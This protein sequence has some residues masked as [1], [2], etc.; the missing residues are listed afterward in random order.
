VGFFH[1]EVKAAPKPATASGR[2][3]LSDIPIHA[4]ADIGCKICP[5][6]DD[7]GSQT[8]LAPVGDSDR[9]GVYLLLPAPTEEDGFVDLSTTKPRN[10]NDP[11]LS[12]IVGY[13]P[14]HDIR[15]GGLVQCAVGENNPSQ[16]E[17]ACCRNRVIADI[18]D[19]KPYVVVGVGDEVLA[20]AT[21]LPAYSP[22]FRGQLFVVKIGA[23]VCYYYQ[24]NAPSWAVKKKKYGKSE[25]E[26]TTAHDLEMLRHS[27]IDL[28]LPDPRTL[29]CEHEFIDYGVEVITGQ[30]PG[31]MQRLEEAMH[32]SMQQRRAAIDIETN[33][34]RPWGKDPHIWMA[35]FGTFER[36]VAFSI[37]HP[38]GWG[39]DHQRRK[40]WGMLG[41]YIVESQVKEAHNLAM[42][43]EWFAFFFGNKVLRCTEWDDTMSMAHTIDERPGTKS[44]GTQTLINFGFDLKKYSNIDVTR[45]L[46]Y[47]IRKTLKYN[48]LDSKWTNRLSRE[49]RKQIEANPDLLY[50]H[51]RKVRLASTLVLTEVMGMPV[52]VTYARQIEK[53]VNAELSEVLGKI[54]R[55]KE[56]IE[57]KQRFGPLELSKDEQVLKLM[58]KICHRDE[59]RRTDRDGNTR[60][61]TD[62]EALK[63][64]PKREVPSAS[65]ILE[66]RGL[67]K[68]K[69]T[70]VLPLTSGKIIGSDG[71]MRSK[72]S[73]M[74]AV[75]GRLAAEDPNAQ[76]WPVRKHRE[77][78]GAIAVQMELELELERRRLQRILLACDYGQIEFRVVGMASDDENLV[79]YCWTGYDVHMFWAKRVVKKYGV[80]VD[81]IVEE[82]EVD[83]DEKGLKTLRQEMKNKWVFPQ[84][85]GSSTQSCARNLKLPDDVA[86]SMGAEF[87]DEFQGVKRWQ[88]KLLKFYEKH[89]YVE[90]LG[91]NKRRGPMSPNEIINMPIQGTACEIVTEAMD[92]I[93]EEAQ[94]EE[95]FDNHP[96][97]NVHDDL[98]FEPP[99]IGLDARMDKIARQM[100][101]HRFDYVNVPL[102]VEMKTGYRWSEMKEV[103]VFRSNE[104]FGLPNPFE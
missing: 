44:L 1:N 32:W 59:I 81:W 38:E 96:I 64:I 8:K 95:D 68:L 62:E 100:C 33:A 19:R 86:E 45:I 91:G 24:V 37:D 50:Q 94:A 99:E 83:W 11:L 2:K 39:S 9:S 78:R 35:S 82:F 56:V 21:G 42:E 36:S 80:I 27:T 75:T 34:L 47:P 93:S 13:L 53:K 73:S 97:L 23:H 51:G 65:L 57:Y 66:H 92:V 15:V 69:S 61:T 49:L 18:E 74:T 90:T 60:L 63:S 46:E 3:K 29:Y 103:K 25:H 104:L 7:K 76:N 31:D 6:N 22:T 26:L 52:D 71:R 5:R 67:A 43:M 10:I 17:Q 41:D 58:D 4:M 48:G 88:A 98:T 77:I 40:V 70:Y 20:W 54:D 28:G 72:Y 16:V 30:E 55:C 87:W 79:K 101:A 89:L 102:V 85:F 84:L 14:R 12:A